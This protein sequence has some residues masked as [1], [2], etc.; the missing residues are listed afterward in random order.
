LLI[1]SERSGRRQSVITDIL[2]KIW[3]CL[4]RGRGVG[5]GLQINRLRGIRTRGRLTQTVMIGILGILGSSL[6]TQHSSLVDLE[7]SVQTRLLYLLRRIVHDGWGGRNGGY[8]ILVASTETRLRQ[9]K[10]Q[11]L[12]VVFVFIQI[13]T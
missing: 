5:L 11:Q 1:L 13:I 6:T 10:I 8:A 2:V 4:S 3:R 12:S 7:W 9:N